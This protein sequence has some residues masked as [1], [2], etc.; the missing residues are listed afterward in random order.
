MRIFLPVLL[1][2]V[3]L[4][5]LAHALPFV[6]IPDLG[7]EFRWAPLLMAAGAFVSGWCVIAKARLA[8]LPY[9]FA[10]GIFLILNAPLF[11]MTIFYKAAIGIGIGL[12]FFVPSIRCTQVHQ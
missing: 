12:L 9:F 5:N 6:L 11:G 7:N 4:A 10:L 1:F 2:F 3:I 8:F